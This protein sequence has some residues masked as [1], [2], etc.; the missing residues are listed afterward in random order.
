MYAEEGKLQI[1][2]GLMKFREFLHALRSVGQKGRKIVMHFRIRTRG[3]KNAHMTHPFSVGENLG[4]CHNG[5]ILHLSKKDSEKSD[6]ARLASLLVREFTDPAKL[7]KNEKARAVIEEYIGKYNK[8]VFMD[9]AG[10][11][12]ILNESEGVWDEGV[13]YSN[14]SFIPPSPADIRAPFMF[15]SSNVWDGWDDDK[16]DTDPQPPTSKEIDAWIRAN[17]RFRQMEQEK[18]ESQESARKTIPAPRPIGA[19][20][21]GAGRVEMRNVPRIQKV[22]GLDGRVH[23]TVVHPGKPSE[24]SSS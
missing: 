18:K 24:T 13:W 5:T 3:A 22:M 21:G 14:S 20:V 1:V 2:K 4:M 10:E 6:S 7:M 12:Y 19:R 16:D 15:R 9:S 8:L 11:V 17:A 23:D